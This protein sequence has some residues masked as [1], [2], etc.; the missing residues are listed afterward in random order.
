MDK[1]LY[2]D[3]VMTMSHLN[4]LESADLTQSMGHRKALNFH[5][6]TLYNKVSSFAS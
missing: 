6:W 3:I 2:I 4:E 1:T 5:N